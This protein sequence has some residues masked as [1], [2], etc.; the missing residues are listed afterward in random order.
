MLWDLVSER[1]TCTCTYMYSIYSDP[2]VPIC[3]C[4]IKGVIDAVGFGK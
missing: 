1:Y 2:N 4:I 3:I